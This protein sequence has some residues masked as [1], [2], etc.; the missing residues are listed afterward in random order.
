M[1]GALNAFPY[2]SASFGASSKRSSVA[3]SAQ[4]EDVVK[5]F[6]HNEADQAADLPFKTETTQIKTV[7]FLRFDFDYKKFECGTELYDFVSANPSSVITKLEMGLKEN[8]TS[9]VNAP[10]IEI[11]GTSFQGPQALYDWL[12]N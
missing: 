2:N 8:A 6:Y 7:A 12:N 4:T 3:L 5:Y 10:T 1:S 9:L 11:G